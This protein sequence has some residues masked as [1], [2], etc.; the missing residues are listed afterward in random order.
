MTEATAA[1]EVRAWEVMVGMVVIVVV[2]VGMG[3]LAAQEVVWVMGVIRVA[4]ERRVGSAEAKEV[5]ACLEEEM[6]SA[7]EMVAEEDMAVLAE[8]TVMPGN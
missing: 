2:A 1:A 5:M 8:L 4:M 3:V 6:G 7:V